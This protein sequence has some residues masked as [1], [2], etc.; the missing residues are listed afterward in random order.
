VQ[1]A[2]V[3]RPL[4]PS[5]RAAAA[6][7]AV[8]A[9]AE[10][11]A[12]IDIGTPTGSGELWSASWRWWE[13]RP[14][15]GL[16]VAA[17]APFGGVLR[18]DAA[19]ERQTYRRAD[20]LVVERRRQ[21]G[22]G[23][24]D[25][26]TGTLWGEATLTVERWPGRRAVGVGGTI[27]RHLAGDRVVVSARGT[28]WSAGAA[29]W[30]GSADAR[31]RSRGETGGS[32]WDIAAGAD[33]VG[34]GAPLAWWPGAGTGHGRAA[35]LRAHPLVRSG[36]IRDGVFGRRLLHASMEWR[37]WRPSG[38]IVRI[39]PAVFLDMARAWRVETIGDGRAHAD[40]GIGMRMRVP[41]AGTLRVDLARGLRDGRTALSIGLG[42]G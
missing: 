41:G 14:R 13:A 35:F 8:R 22:L 39:A 1:A 21:V 34:D 33:A 9:V 36:V 42:P 11:E 5:T 19:D 17:P 29:V 40:A 16:A 28:R 15:V 3:E 37:R 18:L 12:R 4:L 30:R 23:V 24:A 27:E 2:I 32:V 25:W 20:D 38:G 6:A 7:A 31:W 10:R 26:L